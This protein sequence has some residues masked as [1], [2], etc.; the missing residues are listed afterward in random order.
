MGY[1]PYV[2][3]GVKYIDLVSLAPFFRHEEPTYA[4]AKLFNKHSGSG[5]TSAY[6]DPQLLLGRTGEK[7]YADPV[8]LGAGGNRGEAAYADPVLFRSPRNKDDGPVYATAGGRGA[9]NIYYTASR[10]AEDAVYATAAPGNRDSNRDGGALY[11][12]ATPLGEALYD[13][14]RPVHSDEGMYAR[15]SPAHVT[16]P[17]TNAMYARA[18]PAHVTPQAEIIFDHTMRAKIRATRNGGN[19]SRGSGNGGNRG[20]AKGNVNA[21][22]QERPEGSVYTLASPTERNASSGGEL[23]PNNEASSRTS[24]LDAGQ[25][26]LLS[27]I[28]GSVTSP[29]VT[30]GSKPLASPSPGYM[31]ATGGVADVRSSYFEGRGTPLLPSS[32]TDF[33]T[34]KIDMLTVLNK[35]NVNN[36][37]SL[38]D[39]E[40]VNN[41]AFSH[42]SYYYTVVSP[43]NSVKYWK[44]C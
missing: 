31:N 26:N 32:T 43:T 18:S 21:N 33:R 17:P 14:V 3:Y 35:K 42:I 1:A 19:R 6:A 22:G 36:A 24:F 13:I 2:L 25:Q 39:I 7:I 16:S 37:L 23:E 40:Q 34:A 41:W 30:A 11:A 12:T 28:L 5:S 15:A 38:T 10:D 8:L 44:C 9:D 27:S 20:L 4:D 29:H